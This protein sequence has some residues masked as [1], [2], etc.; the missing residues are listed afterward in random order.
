MLAQFVSVIGEFP[1]VGFVFNEYLIGEQPIHAMQGM[2]FER[3]MLGP[4]FL[5][6]NLLG[7]WGCPVHGTALI[8]RSCFEEVGGM[9]LRF[10]LLA[11]VDLWM[12]LSARWD[13]GYVTKPVLTIHQ[14][15]PK[16]YPRDYV[17]FT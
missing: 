7:A 17:G 15:R 9:D 16:D 3:V 11:D 6:E 2:Q 8:R 14:E 4:L 12:R 10:G 5:R 13:V 1:N